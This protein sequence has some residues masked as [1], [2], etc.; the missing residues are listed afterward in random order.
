LYD[1]TSILKFIE[2]NYGLSPLAKRDANA[3][4]MLNAFDFTQLP[5]E[6]LILNSSTVK[7]V[8]HETQKIVDNNN[9]EIKV[10]LIYL[11]NLLA[12]P[13]V[14]LIIWRLT[15]RGKVV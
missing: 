11:T 3:N 14:G 1:V 5:R 9:S 15:Y 6:P 13:T 8:N 2:Y 10:S 4:N 12:I 7:G